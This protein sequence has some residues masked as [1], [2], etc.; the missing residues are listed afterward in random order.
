MVWIPLIV[1][2]EVIVSHKAGIAIWALW[3]GIQLPINRM[4][5]GLER[6][7]SA[8][9]IKCKYLHGIFLWPS[10]GI[11]LHDY[12]V[13]LA[14]LFAMVMW[15]ASYELSTHQLCLAPDFEDFLLISLISF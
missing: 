9:F 12:P 14:T 7:I 3:V 8:V 6:A 11:K 5:H 4:N 15:P 10:I 2:L 13:E 1:K